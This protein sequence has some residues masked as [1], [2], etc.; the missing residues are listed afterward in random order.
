MS[1]RYDSRTGETFEEWATTKLSCR[2]HY[3]DELE[4][5]SAGLRARLAELERTVVMCVVPYEAI[6]MDKLS[7]KWIAPSIWKD[8]TTAIR[9]AR[10]V[11]TKGETHG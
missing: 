8:M 2:D 1:E 9:H 7:R 5:V 11:L 3:I 4:S 10:T 6:L